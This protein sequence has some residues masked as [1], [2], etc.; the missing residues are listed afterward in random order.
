MN[1]RLPSTW[2]QRWWAFVAYAFSTES[3]THALEAWLDRRTSASLSATYARG[4]VEFY[5]KVLSGNLAL[6]RLLVQA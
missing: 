4:G 5:E 1:L 3:L 6:R 2:W